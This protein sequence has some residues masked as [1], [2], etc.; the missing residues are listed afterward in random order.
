MQRVHR[1]TLEHVCHERL[2][3]TVHVECASVALAWSQCRP[4]QYCTV[5]TD[6]PLNEIHRQGRPDWCA[7]AASHYFLSYFCYYLYPAYCICTY[8]LQI[9]NLSGAVT[10]CIYCS[11][12][13]VF[14]YLFCC[15]AVPPPSPLWVWLHYTA[16]PQAQAQGK[17]AAGVSTRHRLECD[18]FIK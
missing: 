7:C 15:S 17:A 8:V 14:L 3:H 10:P 5:C 13:L 11:L 18:P 12:I 2:I 9:P 16:S 6:L 1:L 4:S